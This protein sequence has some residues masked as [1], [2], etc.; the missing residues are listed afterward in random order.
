MTPLLTV[1]LAAAGS[2]MW[3]LPQPTPTLR[4]AKSRMRGGRAGA[5]HL[6]RAARRCGS[7]RGRCR[8]PSRW[9]RW[10]RR[11]T[12][13]CARG[14]RSSRRP[15]ARRCSWRRSWPCSRRG[16][17]RRSTGSRPAG[18]CGSW[19]RRSC[20]GPAH[21]GVEGAAALE[22]AAPG[23]RPVGAAGGRCRRRRGRPGRGSGRRCGPGRWAGSATRTRRPERVHSSGSVLG[24][25]VDA[26]ADLD[27]LL[28][29][30]GRAARGG[31]RADQVAEEGA[32]R[33]AL[34]G[35]ADA[36]EAAAVLDV[37]LERGLLR[38]VERVA[39][40]AEEDD[41][42]VAVEVGGGEVGRVLARRRRRSRSRRRAPRWRSTP[43]STVGVRRPVEDE[44][45]GRGRLS[46]ALRPTAAGQATTNTGRATPSRRRRADSPLT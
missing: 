12:R 3:T 4:L 20:R 45:R 36:D 32:A 31:A 44:D 43:A 46:A 15:G 14:R 19:P 38:G 18:G 39:G 24:R 25:R 35:A 9:G 21:A 6:R 7:R 33:L 41:G 17:C 30:A 22:V 34:G 11:A 23:D 8:R 5:D 28:G 29:R 42:A 26:V 16:P 40:V 10:R 27:D 2:Q 37:A 13:R 1:P